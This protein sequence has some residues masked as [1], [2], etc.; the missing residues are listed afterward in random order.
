MQEDM[1]YYGT[2][3]I[4]SAAGL[5]EKDAE[6]VAYSSQFVDDSTGR[7]SEENRDGGLLSGE[8]S[9]H[10]PRECAVNACLDRPEQR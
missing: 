3:A 8:A 6:I 9:A 5:P 1:H 2:L 7:S 10:H 4:A